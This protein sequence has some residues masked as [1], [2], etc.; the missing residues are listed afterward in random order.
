MK[1]FPTLF[2]ATAMIGAALNADAKISRITPLG[3]NIFGYLG[4]CDDTADLPVGYYEL[5]PQG[6]RLLWED[7]YF[8]E[9][10]LA[11]NNVAKI[12]NKLAGYIQDQVLGMLYGIYYVEYDAETGEVLT[13]DEQDIEFNRS[14]IG[15]FTYNPE[16]ERYYGYGSYN[17]TRC[18]LSA[19]AWDPFNY[20]MIKQLQ[21]KE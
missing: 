8:E 15:V 6:A 14:Y 2:M 1:S 5:E 16:D 12:D 7:P 3:D 21:G 17:G 11:C 4:Y 18:Y 20:R 13:V 10:G 9:T 19:P